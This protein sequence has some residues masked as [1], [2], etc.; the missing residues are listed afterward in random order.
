MTKTP[1]FALR[2]TENGSGPVVLLA[3]ELDLASAPE[4]SACLRDFT[5]ER[6]TLDFTDVTF[7]DSTAISVLVAA[8]KRAFLKGGAVVL[9][10]VQP[11]QM[12]VFEITGL[13][14]RFDFDGQS[15]LKHGHAS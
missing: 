15:T 5:G 9:H 6:V 11:M 1:E 12:R 3:G 10:G 7:M 8:E 14:D 13:L 2:V 4:L